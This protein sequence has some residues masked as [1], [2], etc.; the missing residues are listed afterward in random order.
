MNKTTFASLYIAFFITT[1]L[2]STGSIFARPAGGFIGAPSKFKGTFTGLSWGDVLCPK[3]PL[4]D[5]V[6]HVP[7]TYPT[8]QDAVDAVAVV[9]DAIGS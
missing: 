7:L 3:P 6:Y 2:L 9:E 4:E 8:I 1:V 5:I